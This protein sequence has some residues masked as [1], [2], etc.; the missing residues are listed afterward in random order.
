M[1]LGNG[2]DITNKI[3]TKDANGITNILA[4]VMEMALQIIWALGM[5]IALLITS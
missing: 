3:S 2:N 4:L 5:G 1:A